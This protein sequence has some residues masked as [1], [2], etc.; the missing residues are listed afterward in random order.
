MTTKKVSKKKNG[1]GFFKRYAFLLAVLGFF[2]GMMSETLTHVMTKVID[3]FND[4]ENTEIYTADKATQYFPLE[5]GNV[6]LYEGEHEYS[7]TSSA[8]TKIVKPKIKMEILEIYKIKKLTL[9]VVQGGPYLYPYDEKSPPK[10]AFFVVGNRVFLISDEKKINR[11]IK[12]PYTPDIVSEDDLLFEFPL[13]VGTRYGEMDGLA[14]P[15][16]FFTWH[17][18]KKFKIRSSFS[19]KS[20]DAYL[21]AYK[22]NTEDNEIIFQPYVGIIEYKYRHNGTIDNISFRLVNFIAKREED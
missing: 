15:D 20:E 17:V 19:S 22:M 10:F 18:E 21:L 1:E 2:A 7:Y 4:T 13:S 9:A 14:R 11:I 16:A 6:W 12:E 5:E 3:F 8:K